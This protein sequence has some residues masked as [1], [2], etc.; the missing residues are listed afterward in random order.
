MIDYIIKKGIN[1]NMK[2]LKKTMIVLSVTLGLLSCQN[3]NIEKA[4][5][6]QSNYF[7]NADVKINLF[8][9]LTIDDN[10]NTQIQNELNK[11]LNL[12]F[13][14][15]E[16]LKLQNCSSEEDFNNMLTKFNIINKNEILK[17]L[18]LKV[19]YQQLFISNNLS[20]YRKTVE[21]RK[22]DLDLVMNNFLNVP[23]RNSI[24][25]TLSCAS[26]YNEDIRRCN[27]DALIG[28]SAAIISAASGIVPGLIAAGYV[29]ISHNNCVSDAQYDYNKCHNNQ[30]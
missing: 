5:I 2:N 1:K 25:I 12:N 6:E 29:M 28:S 10:L 16:T 22:L 17:L 15:I 8:E 27:R 18:K 26:D 21:E 11:N 30:Q 14:N 7:K 4:P 13:S 9:F 3:D 23:K 24:Y 20:F 19:H